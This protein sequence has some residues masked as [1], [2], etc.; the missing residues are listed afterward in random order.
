MGTRERTPLKTIGIAFRRI[1]A[2]MTGAALALLAVGVV[3][4][5]NVFLGV[6]TAFIGVAATFLVLGAVFVARAARETAP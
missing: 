5:R 4:G 2:G 6:G 3:A 1:G